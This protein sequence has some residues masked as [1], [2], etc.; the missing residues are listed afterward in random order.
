MSGVRCVW[1]VS[2]P[3]FTLYF[4]GRIFGLLDGGLGDGAMAIYFLIMTISNWKGM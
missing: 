1:M 4:L 2:N 3:M